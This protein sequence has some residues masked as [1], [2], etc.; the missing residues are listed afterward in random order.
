MIVRV[1]FANEEEAR[2]RRDAFR[3]GLRVR[4]NRGRRRQGC[5]H[6]QAAEAAIIGADFALGAV[7]GRRLIRR[8][9]MAEHAAG[10]C[11]RLG[12]N[13]RCAKACD[14]T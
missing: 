1:G 3:A 13:L 2:Q 7:G 4:D 10:L 14:E 6:R 8:G 9:V 12:G 5:G 11:K